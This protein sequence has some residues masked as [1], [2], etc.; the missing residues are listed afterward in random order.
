[1]H[2]RFPFARFFALD[3]HTGELS[4]HEDPSEAENY[5]RLSYQSLKLKQYIRIWQEEVFNSEF[6]FVVCMDSDML[7]AKPFGHVFEHLA[8]RRAD[9]AFT[10]YDGKR[11]VPWGTAD[12]LATTKGKGYVRLQGGM[13]V[14]R[15]NMEALHWF[16]LWTSLTQS[17][18]SDVQAG[19]G[20]QERWQA[21]YKEFKGPSQAALA[22]L[23][24]QGQ[25]ELMQSKEECCSSV[26]TVMLEALQKGG[27]DVEVR[28]LGIPARFLNDAESTEDGTLPKSVHVV[29]LKGHWWRTVLPDGLEHIVVPTRSYEWNREAFELWRLHHKEFAFAFEGLGDGQAGD[30]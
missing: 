30:D 19:V 8:Q 6:S 28:M 2:V 23:L 26:R 3:E 20:Q 17:M 16:A 21:L 18:L 7:M 12:E 4:S 14:M 11:E 24:T 5:R 10:Y 15:N 27:P 25:M 13:L 22:F 1:V 29:H 9:V